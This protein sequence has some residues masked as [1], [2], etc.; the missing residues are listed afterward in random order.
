MAARVHSEMLPAVSHTT[1]SSVCVC[2]KVALNTAAV[3]QAVLRLI[4]PHRQLTNNKMIIM[5]QCLLIC[6]KG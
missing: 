4:L 3:I 5:T 6:V 1:P 2:R